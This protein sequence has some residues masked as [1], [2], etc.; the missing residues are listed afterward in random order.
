MGLEEYNIAE[1]VLARQSSANVQ[2]LSPADRAR[3]HDIPHALNERYEILYPIGEGASAVVYRGRH[4]G[5][6][7]PVAVKYL[8]R[9]ARGGSWAVQSLLREARFLARAEHA[10]VVDVYDFG[11][12]NGRAWLVMEFVDGES[13]DQW[14]S[15][16]GRLSW[17]AVR[18]IML[19]MGQAVAHV[20]S[21]GIIHNDIKP[22]NCM[23]VIGNDG[24]GHVK[25]LD[26]GIAT[27]PGQLAIQPWLR[28]LRGTPAYMAPERISAPGTVQ[29]DIYSLG[30]VMY[31]LLT[32][33]LPFVASSPISMLMEHAERRLEA[34]SHRTPGCFSPGV[35]GLIAHA[36]AKDPR[37]RFDS[38]DSFVRAL[39]DTQLVTVRPNRLQES[40][41]ILCGCSVRVGSPDNRQHGCA[42]ARTP[43]ALHGRPERLEFV[44][45]A[46]R[47]RANFNHFL[48][49]VDHR[50]TKIAG[51]ELRRNR[52]LGDGGRPT[53]TGNSGLFD[54]A[55]LGNICHT[56]KS[57]GLSLIKMP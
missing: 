30:A 13:L 3:T 18:D 28:A 41:S 22:H 34:A 57:P 56:I 1:T 29:S 20:H 37:E 24:R 9:P 44:A 43:R 42:C 40:T 10:N 16:M 26:F 51:G 7:R 27:E 4:R 47:N 55:E 52:C 14:R 39:R 33:S 38:V 25:L 17:A 12:G 46:T 23:W 48:D 32:G 54:L 2:R 50:F 6:D 45:R 36:M 35:D 49:N 11:R 31:E 21:L 53:L 15:R 8:E 19:E 5:I